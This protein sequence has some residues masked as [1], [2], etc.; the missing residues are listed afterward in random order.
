M[1]ESYK[2]NNVKLCIGFQR[3]YD[4]KLREAKYILEKGIIGNVFHCNIQGLWFRT[5]P[6]YLNSSP[7]PENQDEDWEGWRGHWKTEGGSALINQTIHPMDM[8][9]ALAGDLESVSANARIAIHEYIETEDNVSATLT[10]K[11]KALGNLQCGTVYKYD[12]DSWEFYGTKGTIIKDKWKITVK[13]QVKFG[14]LKQLKLLLALKP[15]WQ[16][17]IMTE[18]LEA[19]Q[20]DTPVYVPGEEGRKSIQLIRA[21]YRSILD[22]K[23]IL[24]ENLR[25]DDLKY[26]DLPRDMITHPFVPRI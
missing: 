20:H 6:Y 9:L 5:V 26:P 17:N 7:V 23:K 14:P 2:K 15:I 24:V 18:F 13:G 25:E 8:F 10:F 22:G 12:R 4:K 19:I 11:N 3:R 1:I 16:K 21:I